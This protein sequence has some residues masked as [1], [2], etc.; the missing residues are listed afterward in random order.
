MIAMRATHE[1]LQAIHQGVMAKLVSLLSAEQQA[2]FEKM[3]QQMQH[4][5][6]HG[7]MPPDDE[8]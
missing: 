8:D 4:H 3:H 6:D 1:Q 2:T 7:F 5:G